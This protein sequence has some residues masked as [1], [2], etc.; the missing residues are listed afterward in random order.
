[1]GLLDKA[2]QAI[3]QA[4]SSV[5]RETEYFAIQTQLGGLSAEVERQLVEVGKRTQ[6]LVRQG[7]LQD[8][9]VEVL[10]RRVSELESEMMELRRKAQEL[11]NRPVAPPPPPPPTPGEVPPGSTTSPAP[12]AACGAEVPSGAKFCGACGARVGGD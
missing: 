12:C 4:A 1:M 2:R 7:K 6:E 9:Q 10:L 5:S 3:S 11:Q 8:P